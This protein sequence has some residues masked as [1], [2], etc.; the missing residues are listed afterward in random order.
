MV[1]NLNIKKAVILAGG[2]G[3][4]LRPLTYT[5]PKP[6][7]PINGETLTEHNF[8]ILKKF[9]KIYASDFEGASELRVNLMETKN[10]EE[11]ESVIHNFNHG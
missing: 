4:R 5:V 1:I 9:F 3:T 7:I 2:L 11:V 10:L 6:L 8:N